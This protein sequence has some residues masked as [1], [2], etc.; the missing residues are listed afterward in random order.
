[1]LT[2]SPRRVPSSQSRTWSQIALAADAA[3][4]MFRNCDAHGSLNPAYYYTTMA[5]VKYYDYYKYYYHY[6]YDGF[7]LSYYYYHYYRYLL[8]IY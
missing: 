5:I 4:V 8:F 6:D 3:G 1:M 7:Y 2:H